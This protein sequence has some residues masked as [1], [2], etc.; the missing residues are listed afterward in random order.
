[1][2]Y[3]KH[4]LH[5][6]FYTAAYMCGLTIFLINPYSKS[7]CPIFATSKNAYFSKNSS[8]QSIKYTLS[9]YSFFV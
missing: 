7:A 5:I 2:Q 3:I 1:M 9:L 8:N 6:L 4:I